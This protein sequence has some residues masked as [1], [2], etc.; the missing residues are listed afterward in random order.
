VYE[1]KL[2]T[3]G[4]VTTERI[5]RRFICDKAR[6]RNRLRRAFSLRQPSFLS[7]HV[8]IERWGYNQILSLLI[9]VLRP[10]Y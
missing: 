4:K 2:Y 8:F 3:F 1:G 10:F 6:K 9:A 7:N 5:L